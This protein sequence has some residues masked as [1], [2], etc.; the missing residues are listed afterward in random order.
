MFKRE[1]NVLKNKES[2][3]KKFGGRKV[4][5]GGEVEGNKVGEEE[6]WK[7]Q[8]GRSVRSPFS[9]FESFLALNFVRLRSTSLL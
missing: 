9:S 1:E 7:W 3:G 2:G 4:H 6:C 5:T 8:K